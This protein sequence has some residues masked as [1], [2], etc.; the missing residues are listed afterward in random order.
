MAMTART[1]DIAEKTAQQLHSVGIDLSQ[2][3]VLKTDLLIEKKALESEDD[4]KYTKGILF[5]GESNNKGKVL[6]HFLRI[7]KLSPKKI[8]FVDDKVKHVNNVG[9]ALQELKIP[10]FGFRYG[11]VDD[12]V[13]QFNQ[14]MADVVDKPT[15]ELYLHG[16]LNNEKSKGNKR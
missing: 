10:Y 6:A 8:V 16:R 15:A 2:N 14:V 7:N 11:A 5:V 3:T 9:I 4:A 1:L 12:K 13:K